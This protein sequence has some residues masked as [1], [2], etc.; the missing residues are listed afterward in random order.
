V[1]PLRLLRVDQDSC[2]L[3]RSRSRAEVGAPGT[4]SLLLVVM[5][6]MTATTAAPIMAPRVEGE[7]VEVR[8]YADLGAAAL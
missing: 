2:G 1:R 4:K 5:H 7:I 6:G 8:S 3:L